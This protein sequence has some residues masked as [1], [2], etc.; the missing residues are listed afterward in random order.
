LRATE[1]REQLQEIAQ[2]PAGLPAVADGGEEPAGRNVQLLQPAVDDRGVFEGR[3]APLNELLG[4]PL[5][6]WLDPAAGDLT[7]QGLRVL[8]QRTP[9]VI[10]PRGRVG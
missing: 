1:G 8:P 9:Q 2:P 7:Q 4:W 5:T 3:D 6:S 10:G